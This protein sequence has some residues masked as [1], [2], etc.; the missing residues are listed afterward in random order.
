MRKSNI[1]INFN[2]FN[3]KN[4]NTSLFEALKYMDL[5]FASSYKFCHKTGMLVEIILALAAINLK[6]SLIPGL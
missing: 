4:R 2:L 3:D 5:I 1:T 6:Q